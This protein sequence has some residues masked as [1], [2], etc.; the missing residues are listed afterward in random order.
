MYEYVHMYDMSYMY[1]YM[2]NM[3]GDLPLHFF[4]IE[5]LLAKICRSKYKITI[6]LTANLVSFV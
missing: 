4:V 5:F 2:Y 3:S 6:P 1:E